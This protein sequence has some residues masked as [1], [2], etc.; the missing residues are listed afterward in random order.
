M[1]P[2]SLR[3]ACREGSFAGYTAGH[4]KGFV[5]ANICILPRDWAEDFLLFC[6]RNPQP[7]PLLSRSD[8]GSW[9]LPELGEDIDIRSDVP[10]YHVFREGRFDAEVADITDLWRNDLVTFAMGCSFSF[11]E[12]LVD[13]GLT[14]RFLDRGEVAGVYETTMRA[15]PAGRYDAPLLMTMRPFTPADAI[16]AIQITSRFPN[17][18]GAPVH[19]GDP[20]QIGVELDNR[21]RGVGSGEVLPG[22]I[23]LFWACGL[24]PQLA[25]MTAKP[26][27]CIT[28][29]PSSMLFTDIRN[30]SLAAL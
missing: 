10:R 2:R 22:E 23:P 15:K 17:V 8:V 13:A 7:C 9:S 12:A 14:L 3:V 18:H 30:A 25:V 27:I 29:A 4:A 11:E 1:T 26:P 21:Y 19:L 5:Q 20:G 16:R 6:Q 24:T 28:H